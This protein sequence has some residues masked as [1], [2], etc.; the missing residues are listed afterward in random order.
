MKKLI[1]VFLI[2]LTGSVSAGWQRDADGNYGWM[3]GKENFFYGYIPFLDTWG[4]FDCD[5]G[6]DPDPATY[7]ETISFLDG[8]GI[9]VTGNLGGPSVTWGLGLLSSDWNAG[10]FD[11]EAVD[12]IANGTIGVNHAT[13]STSGIY[14]EVPAGTAQEGIYID[15]ITNS[16]ITSFDSFQT[17]AAIDGANSHLRG[18]NASVQGTNDNLTQNVRGFFSFVATFDGT[19][20]DV[21]Y[22]YQYEVNCASDG[23]TQYGFFGNADYNSATLDNYYGLYLK[24]DQLVCAGNN[25]GVY[26]DDVHSY[27]GDDVQVVGT[28]AAT[29]VTGVNVTSGANP[30]HTH[31]GTSLSNIDHGAD[32]TGASLLDNDHPQY[33]LNVN[34][35][36]NITGGTFDM[37][38]IGDIVAAKYYDT[39]TTYYLDPGSAGLSLNVSGDLSIGVSDA[40]DNDYIYFDV[41][42]ESIHWDNANTWFEFSDDLYVS[43]EII[44]NTDVTAPSNMFCGQY[45]YHYGDTDTS[46]LYTIDQVR[47][48]A[49]GTQFI[50][51][52]EPVIGNDVLIINDGS[53]DMDFQWE[54]NTDVYGLFCQGSNGYIGIG[55][56][57]PGAL[58]DVDGGMRAAYNTNTTSYLGRG[59][60]GY[61]GFSDFA[62]F[63]HLDRNTTS[64]YCLMQNASGASY[65]N[66]TSGQNFNFR[67]NGTSETG[68]FI[69]A[70]NDWWFGSTTSF[71]LDYSS[72]YAGF[73]IITPEAK[74]HSYVSNCSQAPLAGTTIFGETSGHSY[75]TI[76]GGTAHDIGINIA[77]SGNNQTGYFLY[78]TSTNSN[79]IKLLVQAGGTNYMRYNAPST[80]VFAYSS[81]RRYKKKIHKFKMTEKLK[82]KYLSIPTYD[83]LA[84]GDDNKIPQRGFMA[85]DTFEILPELCVMEWVDTDEKLPNSLRKKRKQTDRVDG[86]K[87]DWFPVMNFEILKEHENRITTTE[88][89]MDALREMVKTLVKQNKKLE[90]RI[91][92]LERRQ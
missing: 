49:G 80:E 29:T 75:I 55:T 48:Y 53:G 7:K 35:A 92:N 25:Y 20:D 4:K 61:C 74:I 85:E 8:N 57:G 37:T 62:S 18:F 66:C 69:G 2:L 52:N 77:E 64:N 12:F 67:E 30:G 73:G 40:G 15:A 43:G 24:S 50:N 36:T 54:S 6:T 65:L 71:Y 23:G 59:A 68:K 33:V 60:F 1:L 89:E 14:I 45:I 47:V 39:A 22:G 19:L 3:D 78:N 26:V 76:G 82:N 21:G 32:C 5:N 79:Y 51:C 56:G 86:V 46:I 70:S 90:K 9:D 11:I 38:T 91:K 34:E 17:V 28:M 31:T 27:F 42:A 88:S 58:L 84:K 13:V 10:S 72:K 87:H 41:N 16:Q 83:Y 44:A 63:S 81:S